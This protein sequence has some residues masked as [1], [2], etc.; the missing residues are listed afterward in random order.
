MSHSEQVRGHAVDNIEMKHNA[1]KSLNYA[2]A[3]YAIHEDAD[4][5][6][7]SNVARAKTWVPAMKRQ[8]ID[9]LG[10]EC[11]NK[12][13]KKIVVFSDGTEAKY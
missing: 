10:G 5:I 9:F 4:E 8:V 13:G 7:R 1:R 2:M 6:A 11:V 3:R 12:G